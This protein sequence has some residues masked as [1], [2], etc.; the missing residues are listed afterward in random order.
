MPI[1]KCNHGTGPELTQQ[2]AG[3]CKYT[4]KLA[5]WPDPTVVLQSGSGRQHWH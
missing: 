1:P 4:G 5:K 2:A 3:N